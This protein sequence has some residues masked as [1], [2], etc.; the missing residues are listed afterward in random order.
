MN[1]CNIKKKLQLQC[2][3]LAWKSNNLLSI[4]KKGHNSN[5]K[6]TLSETFEWLLNFKFIFLKNYNNL[7]FKLLNLET[8]RGSE[9][10]II[11]WVRLSLQLF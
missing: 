4:L 8:T 5:S 6:E 2:Q 1:I 7:A 11:G 9:P 3:N 10:V